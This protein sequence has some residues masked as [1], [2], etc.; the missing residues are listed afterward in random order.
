MLW[1]VCHRAAGVGR[2]LQKVLHWDNISAMPDSV[3]TALIGAGG[4]VLGACIN[5]A[6]ALWKER[7]GARSLPTRLAACIPGTWSGI[8]GELIAGDDRPR[9]SF[10][11]MVKFS[12]KRARL[13]GDATLTAPD[14]AMPQFLDV[15]GDFYD[16]DI[17]QLRY[18]SRD[19][20]RKQPGVLLL[21]LNASGTK[22]AGYYAGFSP[23]R[24]IFVAGHIEVQKQL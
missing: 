23:T 17:A 24:N 18:W 14:L 9:E 2:L 16:Q 6:A 1:C 19:D 10:S 7:S 21:S 5:Q 12:V 3:V 13:L 22:L 11:V 4:T 8:G 15:A 20:K